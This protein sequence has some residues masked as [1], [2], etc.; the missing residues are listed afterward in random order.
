M[1]KYRGAFAL[2]A[3]F[4]GLL[5]LRAFAQRGLAL[6]PKNAYVI[7]LNSSTNAYFNYEKELIEHVLL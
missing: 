5:P 1:L 6:Q 4:A 3:K 7:L 2:A